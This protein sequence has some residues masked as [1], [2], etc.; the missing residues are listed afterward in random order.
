[1]NSKIVAVNC[2]IS[3]LEEL[4]GYTIEEAYGGIDASEEGF[5]IK[6]YKNVSGTR[7]YRDFRQEDGEYFISQ[8][9]IPN[10]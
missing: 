6:A 7:I 2:D 4:S 9:Y 3:A 5:L 10:M 1:M 8:E